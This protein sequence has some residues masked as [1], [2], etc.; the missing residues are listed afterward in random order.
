M[1]MPKKKIAIGGV[2]SGNDDKLLEVGNPPLYTPTQLLQEPSRKPRRAR[3]CLT[4]NFWTWD[5][6]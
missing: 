3:G 1:A 5:R 4:G 2:I 6:K